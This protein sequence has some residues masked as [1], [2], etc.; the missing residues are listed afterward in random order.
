MKRFWLAIL[1][2]CVGA[3]GFSDSS[4]PTDMANLPGNGI[5]PLGTVPGV[6]MSIKYLGE[7]FG[8]VGGTISSPGNVQ[9]LQELFGIFNQAVLALAS[10]WIGYTVIT[11]IFNSAM[12]GGFITSQRKQAVF[13]FARLAL[14]FALLL[15]L[16]SGYN[17]LQV[18]GMKALLE[19]VNLANKVWDQTVLFISKK[20]I[21]HDYADKKSASTVAIIGNTGWVAGARIYSPSSQTNN[22]TGAQGLMYNMLCTAYYGAITPSSMASQGPIFSQKA[23]GNPQYIN[24]PSQDSATGCGSYRLDDPSNAQ[25][26]EQAQIEQAMVYALWSVAQNVVGAYGISPNNASGTAPDDTSGLVGSNAQTIANTLAN[27]VSSTQLN[28]LNNKVPTTSDYT[29]DTSWEVQAADQG[30]FGAGRFYWLL[31]QSSWNNVQDPT[32]TAAVIS[33]P[34]IAQAAPL[35]TQ[36]V[37]LASDA[38]WNNG[39]SMPGSGILNIKNVFNSLG[40]YGTSAGLIDATQLAINYV[41]SAFSSDPTGIN[42][43][44]NPIGLCTVPWGVDSKHL[45][46]YGVDFDNLYTN[47]PID[48]TGTKSSQTSYFYRINS[49]SDLQ[50]M[51]MT[52]GPCGSS[53]PTFGLFNV[54][55]IVAYAGGSHQGYHSSGAQLCP[56]FG[57]DLSYDVTP[58]KVGYCDMSEGAYSVFG[59][60]IQGN[61]AS[62]SVLGN[63]QFSSKGLGGVPF[64]APVFSQIASKFAILENSQSQG[65]TDPLYFMTQLGQTMLGAAG[66]LW[67]NGYQTIYNMAL[68]QGIFSGIAPG[69]TIFSGFISWWE[70]VFVAVG[71]GLFAAGFMLCFYAPLYPFVLYLLG[72]INWLMVCVEF[73]IALPLVALGVT[74]PE[75]HDF[76]GKAEVAL[77]L[78]L[79]ACLRPVL[80]VLGF[81]SGMVMSFI[82]F[83]AIN[84]MYS[85]VLAFVFNGGDQTTQGLPVVRAIY[86]VVTSDWSGQ[87]DQANMTH[88]TFGGSQTTDMILIPLLMVFYGYLVVEVVHFCFTLIHQ[89]PEQVLRWIGGPVG[90]DRTQ[91][92]A[93]KIQSGVSGAVKQAGDLQG[94]ATTGAGNAQGGAVGGSIGAGI[95]VAKEAAGM[96]MKA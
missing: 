6:D 42:I 14:G 78:T 37:I 24:F 50:G 55:V 1:L 76:L 80:M 36:S 94:K 70:P 82:G 69:S 9:L 12:E 34:S 15:P 40:G 41:N 51:V 5:I 86:G 18:L 22:P 48:Q 20:G 58:Q 11:T 8:S 32:S 65:L 74:H 46:N 73:M 56:L 35:A 43:R 16:S 66:Q 84:Y 72:A 81:M 2:L 7:L 68:W 64:I 53:S 4:S 13:I 57:A 21:L 92:V 38:G 60:T 96:A 67:D 52:L 59:N 47:G 28:I 54:P 89:L 87:T 88:S 85:S 30:W 17:S 91:G 26:S 63:P 45:S 79:S 25:S 33:W 93:D 77:M 75:G 95:S 83:S 31:S 29:K 23:A 90:Q 3:V 49:L 19:G 62:H 61:D 44:Y 27:Y 71:G 10:A 39:N